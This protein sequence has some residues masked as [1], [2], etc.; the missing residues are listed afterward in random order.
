MVK[1][2]PRRP[3]DEPHHAADVPERGLSKW[4]RGEVGQQ[5]GRDVEHA[6]ARGA[7]GVGEHPPL[8]PLVDIERIEILVFEPEH[9]AATA[10]V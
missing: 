7:G 6:T 4:Q 3:V 1:E 9:A 2:V 10:R 8:R 5:I